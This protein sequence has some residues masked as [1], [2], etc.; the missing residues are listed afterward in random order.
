[1]RVAYKADLQPLQIAHS[2]RLTQLKAFNLPTRAGRSLGN[3]V[4]VIKILVEI[5]V[6]HVRTDGSL[7]DVPPKHGRF[8]SHYQAVTRVIITHT[9]PVSYLSCSNHTSCHLSYIVPLSHFRPQA[10]S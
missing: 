7:N 8:G 6:R 4:S 1:M 2:H 10:I 5:D 3:A 9:K